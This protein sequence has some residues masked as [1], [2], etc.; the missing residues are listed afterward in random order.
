MNGASRV[1]IHFQSVRT[2]ERVK[3]R[4]HRSQ[5]TAD[6]LDCHQNEYSKTIRNQTNY[7]VVASNYKE[8]VAIFFTL[9]VH[10]PE[11]KNVN[12]ITNRMLMHVFDIMVDE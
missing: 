3:K 12:K 4:R 7:R 2:Q 11:K 6:A 1:F 5:K 10:T 9:S 8:N